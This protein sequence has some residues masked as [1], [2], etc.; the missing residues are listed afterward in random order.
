MKPGREL[1]PQMK[2]L[3]GD[4]RDKEGDSFLEQQFQIGKTGVSGDYFNH[5]SGAIS[6]L[7]ELYWVLKEPDT[8]GANYERTFA[9]DA[10][11]VQDGNEQRW[12]KVVK[13]VKGVEGAKEFTRFAI[14][15]EYKLFSVSPGVRNSV[16]AD[17][18]QYMSSRLSMKIEQWERKTGQ[19]IDFQTAWRLFFAE[20]AT[21]HELNDLVCTVRENLRQLLVADQPEQREVI[22]QSSMEIFERAKEVL[23]GP[24]KDRHW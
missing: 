17:Y 24:A 21:A 13:T 15:G 5:L 4:M 22:H 20:N 14:D 18:R 1:L 6:S 19:Q 11:L 23:Y 16:L 10:I 2:E 12:E 8:T 7:D 9:T 3:G